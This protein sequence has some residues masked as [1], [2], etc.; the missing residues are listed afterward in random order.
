MIYGTKQHEYHKPSKI[1]KKSKINVIEIE[2]LEWIRKYG[3]IHNL[4]SYIIIGY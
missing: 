3:N 2:N 1:V 4:Y